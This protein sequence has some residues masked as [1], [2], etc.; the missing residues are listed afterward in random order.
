M[1]I[2]V[3]AQ[4]SRPPRRQP[5]AR[6]GNN[7]TGLADA[8]FTTIQKRVLAL[9]FGQPSRR[10]YTSELIALTGSGSGAVHRELERLASSGL[11]ATAR[12]GRLFSLQHGAFRGEL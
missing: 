12:L 4:S 8:L 1:G 11:V 6:G 10:F 7:R 3:T 5:F 2:G 9:L